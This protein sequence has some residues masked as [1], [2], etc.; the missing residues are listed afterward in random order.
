VEYHNTCGI[1]IE[2]RGETFY[3]PTLVWYDGGDGGLM[4]ESAKDRAEDG[5]SMGTEGWSA[6]PEAA[7]NATPAG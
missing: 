4:P 5:F 2:T 1:L 6:L 3:S 7:H